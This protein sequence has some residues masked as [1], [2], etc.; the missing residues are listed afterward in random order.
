ML[1]V[2]CYVIGVIGYLSSV[3]SMSFTPIKRILP[4][5]M[6]R[7]GEKENIEATIVLQE[8]LR[9]V[10]M[11]FGK[12][13]SSRIKPLSVKHGTLT[14]SCMSSVVAQE[15]RLRERE[16]IGMLEKKFGKQVQTLR[17]FL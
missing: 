17:F 6:G 5:A 7:T 11:L 3:I 16:I 4:G 9:I 8:F 12:N 15:I 2:M 14:Y 10:N 1:C 13:V